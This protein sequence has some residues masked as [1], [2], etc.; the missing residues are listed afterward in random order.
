MLLCGLDVAPLRPAGCGRTQRSCGLRRGRVLEARAHVAVHLCRSS[1]Y[2]TPGAAVAA[3]AVRRTAEGPCAV[4]LGSIHRRRSTAGRPVTACRL[5]SVYLA[6]ARCAAGCRRPP[7]ARMDPLVVRSA[8][9]LCRL[10]RVCLPAFA[11]RKPHRQRRGRRVLCGGRFCGD[12]ELAAD[13]SGCGLASF[14]SSCSISA[15]CAV[16]VRCATPSWPADF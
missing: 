5:Q 3:G 2:R 16:L 13:R 6:S 14:A 1:R 8:A 4:A 11:R 10:V 12:H 15:A 7:E 9:H